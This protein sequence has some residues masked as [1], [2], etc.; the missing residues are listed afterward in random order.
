[1]GPAVV[2]MSRAIRTSRSRDGSN[3]LVTGRPEA[4]AGPRMD[5]PDRVARRVL[6]DAGEPRW[7]LGES[8]LRPGIAAP[9]ILVE[10]VRGGDGP[11]PDEERVDEV[12][13]LDGR[14][15]REQVADAE[16]HRVRSRRRRADRP[17]RGTRGPRAR[18]ARGSRRCAGR[19]RRARTRRASAR[20]PTPRDSP[21]R[22]R[23]A[24][25]AGPGAGSRS[26]PSATSRRPTR[27]GPGRAGGCSGRWSGRAATRSGGRPR[28]GGRRCPSTIGDRARPGTSPR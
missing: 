6:A 26:R 8:G 9:A 5:A 14:L 11:R 21:G 1:M 20:R 15:A 23:A 24:R 12:A 25:P 28:T 18:R 19:G 3:R 16:R 27:A 4:G 2:W 22:R 7:I 13:L 17:G 10:Q